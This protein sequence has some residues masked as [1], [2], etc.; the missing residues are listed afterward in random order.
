MVSQNAE[1][2]DNETITR[3]TM[4]YP[5]TTSSAKQPGKR[6]VRPSSLSE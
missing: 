1:M 2:M 3:S 5:T 6:I 4:T